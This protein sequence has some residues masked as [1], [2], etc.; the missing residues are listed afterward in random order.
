MCVYA[1]VVYEFAILRVMLLFYAH[2]HSREAEP[3]DGDDGKPKVSKEAKAKAAAEKEQGT[4]CYKKR[5]F[6]AAL[7]VRAFPNFRERT[8]AALCSCVRN[9]VVNRCCTVLCS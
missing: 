9:R 5:E 7:K 4:A 8:A 1:C 2:S 6:E 3:M